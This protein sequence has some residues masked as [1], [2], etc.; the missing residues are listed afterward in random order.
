MQVTETL[1]DGL[2]RAFTVIVPAGDIETR[3]TARLA[4]LGKSLRLPGFRPG[5]VP[6]TIVRQRYGTA[7]TAPA[8]PTRTGYT[9]AGWAATAES[10]VALADLGT[11]DVDLDDG[12]RPDRT[13]LG[14]LQ[15]EISTGH[16]IPPGIVTAARCAAPSC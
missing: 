8:D 5:K 12:V 16:V 7:V 3:R 2:K 11:L 6:M 15:G 1:S 14:L 13:R 10:K 4:D 9:F